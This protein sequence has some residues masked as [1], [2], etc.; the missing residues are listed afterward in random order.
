MATLTSYN[1]HEFQEA[2]KDKNKRPHPN[3]FKEP[4]F[5]AI[6]YGITASNPHNTQAWKFKISN[7]NEM[8]LFVDV[9][10]ILPETDPTNRQIHI[11]CGCFLETASV[12]MT[13]EG[14][15]SEIDYFP[16]GNYE[17]SN[18]G[19]FPVAKLTIRKDPNTVS[20]NL[21]KVLLNRKTSRLQFSSKTISTSTWGRVLRLIG[22]HHNEITLINNE[23]TLNKIRPILSEGMK[24]ESYTFHTNEESRKWFRENDSRI[25]NERDGINLPG[26][27]VFGIKKWFAEKKLK[28]LDSSVW[29][30]QRTIDYTL[31][32]HHRK[33]T[34]SPNIITIKSK[35]NTML[36][37]VKAGQ[38]YT[39]LQLACLANN[40]YMH[41]LS[42]VLQE[43]E[44]MKVLKIKFEEAMNVKE[45]EKIQMVVRVGKSKEPYLSYRRK[46]NDMVI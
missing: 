16:K 24:I 21:N 17:A 22:D 9:T 32:K 30:N 11:G 4:I 44:E 33:V 12:G 1:F 8:F 38:D 18:L 37:W 6:A 7:K 13:Q 45:D 15:I 43:F 5:K 46:L 3:D 39:R 35:T 29:N 36:D 20:S 42:Q 41:P 27:G 26:N 25:E 40:F 2:N 28:G 14:F 23:K 34:S 10:R 19:T 31:K